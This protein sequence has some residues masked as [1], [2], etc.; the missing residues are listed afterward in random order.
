[1]RTH[2]YQ[3]TWSGIYLYTRNIWLEEHRSM[4]HNCDDDYN[5]KKDEDENDGAMRTGMMKRRRKRRQK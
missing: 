3:W 1:M 2:R 4:S 5:D